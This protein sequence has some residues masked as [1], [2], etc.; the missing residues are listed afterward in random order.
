MADS[1]EEQVP[2]EHTYEI[3]QTKKGKNLLF[4]KHLF[5]KHED[6]DYGT[7]YRCSTRRTSSC[8]GSVFVDIYDVL[9]VINAD[10]ICE[11]AEWKKRAKELA[12]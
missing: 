9:E 6:T 8:P 11:E 1:D 3:I 7:K 10:H 12:D 4:G 2:P 5:S